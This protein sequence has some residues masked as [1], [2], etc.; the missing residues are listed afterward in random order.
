MMGDRIGREAEPSA[1]FVVE[2]IDNDPAAPQA[3]VVVQ[4]VDLYDGDEP[5]VR[6]SLQ[7][8][9]DWQMNVWAELE[10]A[11]DELRQAGRTRVV[12]TGR[13]RLPMWF[14]AGCALREVLGFD[15]ATTQ[16]AQ[17]WSSDEL[18][19]SLE[20]V[21]NVDATGDGAGLAVILSIK[22]HMGPKPWSAPPGAARRPS[23]HRGTSDGAGAGAVPDG[24]TAAALA[25]RPA[26]CRPC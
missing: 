26:G 18:G 22:L 20:L 24:P 7:S 10:A 23:P 14:G 5:F 6:R 9:A 8:G 13:M 2:G 15:V 21:S 17:R 16:R 12:V 25:V 4:F 11:A 1:L 3:D 19:D